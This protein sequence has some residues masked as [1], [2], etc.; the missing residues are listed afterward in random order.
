MSEKSEGRVMPKT[1]DEIVAEL[2][3]T[4]FRGDADIA[5]YA[6]LIEETQA[7]VS[8]AKTTLRTLKSM[9]IAPGDDQ[10]ITPA[11]QASDA[12]MTVPNMI[13]WVM[14]RNPNKSFD[15]SQM[16]SEIKN[17]LGLEPDPNHVR[18]TLW[19]M[20]KDGRLAQDNDGSYRLPSKE[21][22]ADDVT[23]EGPSAGESEAPSAQ[24]REAG[25]G[26]GP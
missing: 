8:D 20:K 12:K 22:P 18:P 23:V 5:R 6:K 11:H 17:T 2:Q 15:P 25:P 16:I 14:Q 26:G 9:G 10:P 13:F 21:I 7:N 4:V 24:G 19:R 1:I 3:N